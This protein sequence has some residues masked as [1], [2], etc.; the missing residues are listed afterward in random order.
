MHYNREL[1]MA[2]LSG[3]HAVPQRHA[4]HEDHQSRRCSNAYATFDKGASDKFIIDP[5]GLIP[6]PDSPTS[7]E[8][9][10]IQRLR[11]FSGLG[12]TNGGTRTV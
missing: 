1:M 4:Q 9:M 8:V 10:P 6:Q 5:H 11:D 12:A 7:L 3:P 2:I